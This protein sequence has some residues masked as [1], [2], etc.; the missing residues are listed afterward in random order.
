MFEYLKGTIEDVQPGYIVVDVNG[1]GYLVY[2]SN[3]YVY[4]VDNKKQ[5]K[6]FIHQAVTDSSQL[7]YGFS[8]RELKSIF[9]KL[10]NVSGIGPKS[11]LAIIA[12]NDPQSL[13]NAINTENVTYL[14]KFP[15]VGQKTAKQIILDLKGKLD[16]IAPS[17]FDDFTAESQPAS[18][19]KSD[20]QALEDALEALSELGYS[21]RDIKKARK[22]LEDIEVTSTED[23]LRQGLSAVT[24][25]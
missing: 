4:Q 22:A 7:L 1:V 13:L 11:A 5:V 21:A 18:D 23:Y 14:T 25:F 19:D 15:G 20:N 17:L 3:P 8:S 9:E 16:D 2:T 6:V 24:K 10:L 12:G